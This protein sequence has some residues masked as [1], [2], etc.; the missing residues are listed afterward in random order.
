MGMLGWNSA[1]SSLKGAFLPWKV[2]IWMCPAESWNFHSSASFGMK[3]NI[4]SWLVF[5]AQIPG[6]DTALGVFLEYGFQLQ[7][8]SLWRLGFSHWIC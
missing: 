1:L 7:T 2:P 4:L 6:V 8:G 3:F 5:A